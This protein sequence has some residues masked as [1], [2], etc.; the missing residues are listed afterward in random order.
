VDFRVY[1]R[2][3]PGSGTGLTRAEARHQGATQ[4]YHWTYSSA[5][6]SGRGHLE[7]G[8]VNHGT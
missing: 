2:A 8:K 5:P 1:Q 6:V 3:K 4:A 7:Q